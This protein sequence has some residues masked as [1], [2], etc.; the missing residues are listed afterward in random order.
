MAVGDVTA[1]YRE[2][3]GNRVLGHVLE[4]APRREKGFGENVVDLAR[5]YTSGDVAHDALGVG[6]VQEPEVRFSF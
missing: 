1:G 5:G 6:F 4:P 3:P 2:Q